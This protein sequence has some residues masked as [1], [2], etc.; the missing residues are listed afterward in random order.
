M[1]ILRRP[2][3]PP[4]M[5]LRSIPLAILTFLALLPAALH[6]SPVGA[7]FT[8]QGRLTDAG[9]PAQGNFDLRFTLYDSESGGGTTGAVL[10]E[11]NV[12]VADG[13]FSVSLDFGGGVFDGTSRWLQIEVRAAGVGDFVRL[14][15]RQALKPVPYALFA[16]S[17]NPG[18]QGAKGDPGATGATGLTGPQGPAG[19]K[20]DKGDV[21]AT[22]PAGPKGNTGAVGPAGPQGSKGDV[23]ATGATGSAGPQ[24]PAGAKGD[25]G[26]TG[27]TGPA[28]AQ[29]PAGPKGD[30]GLTGPAG[31][32]GPKGDP[33]ATGATGLAGPQG[34]AGAKGDKGDIGATGPA[35][36]QGPQGPAGPKGN[37][38]A[39]GP[40]GPQGPIGLTGATGAT[41]AT[42]PQGARGLTG[43][44]GATGAA[45]P[46]G[47]QGLRGLAWRSE[48]NILTAY[49]KDDAVSLGGAAW[50]AK[51]TNTGSAPAIGNTNW[52]LLADK[53]AIGLQG[54]AG[55]PGPQGRVGDTGSAGPAG[56]QGA[57]GAVG[58][59]GPQGPPGPQG[60]PGSS[61]AWS[62]TGNAGTTAGSNFL[63]TTDE[64]P[65]LLQAAGHLGLQVQPS[66]NV[67]VGTPTAVAN[68][69]L[70]V[71]GTI[72]FPNVAAPMFFIYPSGTLNA[73]KPV[74][75]HSPAFPGYGLY[76][77]DDGDRF[78]MK[79]S[80]SDSTPSL[81][82]DLDSNW[83]AI[84]S[85]LGK[86]GYEL[87]V[88]GQIVCEDI[89]IQDSSLWPDYVF[90]PGYALRPL[91]EVEA[92]IR[93]NKHLPG[94]PNA[95]TVA[96]DGLRVSDM[97]K[98][99]MEK[100]E[101]LT[102]YI[103]DQNK[104]LAAQEQRIAEMQAVLEASRKA[105]G[106]TQVVGE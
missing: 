72:G 103:I 34:P 23:G 58:A 98:R 30:T 91:E 44:A 95:A 83:V 68:S 69:R 62:R 51:M 76:Y 27:A 11:S 61:D 48:W 22:G 17:G 19:A 43:A 87:S 63:G 37:T 45:G 55:A 47:P 8:Y 57:D 66:G 54:P 67:S 29:G 73:E 60:L 14:A 50:L 7:A 12:V 2:E 53:G 46:A 35:G 94:V 9:A 86:P 28:G 65:L 81:V 74:I 71:D 13:I 1:V 26:D 80:P 49:S 79:S 100:I 102:L 77:R 31:P 20:G 106:T 59:P 89:L 93:E 84:A 25:K 105:G 92:H 4:T 18:P 52:D 90:E 78:V 85:D 40:A 10:T 39:T 75:M 82:V 5:N 36:A 6:A 101:E 64:Q 15:P 99:M 21:G 42:G 104:R 70:T 3:V 88:N 33:G 16:A 38:G 24:G 96:K 41:G 56:P 32:Q 97:N